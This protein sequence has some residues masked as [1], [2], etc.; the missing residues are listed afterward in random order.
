LATISGGKQDCGLRIA[1]CGLRIAECLIGE[2][3]IAIP[4][5]SNFVL[6]PGR[7]KFKVVSV[8]K[9]K[10]LLDFQIRNPQPAIRNLTPM[11]FHL[12]MRLGGAYE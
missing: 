2:V 12:L 7:S 5:L 3:I 8:L 11:G 10:Q 4:A 9:R 6:A 1:D